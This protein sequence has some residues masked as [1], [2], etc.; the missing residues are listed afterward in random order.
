MTTPPTPYPPLRIVVDEPTKE[1]GLG[2]S[3][4]VDA[5]ASVAIGGE[6]ARFTIGIYGAWG[7]GKSSIL[8]ALDHKLSELDHPVVNFDAWRYARN[9][10]VIVPLLHE[11]EAALTTNGDALWK[12]IARGLR[13]ITS[14]ISLSAAG[15]NVS[16]SAIGN[17]IDA[18]REPRERWRAEV[19]H[20]RLQEI[21]K[22]LTDAER[23][24]VILVDDLDRC[25]PDA[26]VQLLEAIHAL[27]D[28]QGFVF[29][30]ALDYEVLIKA[31]T[32]KYA[33]AD[34]ALFIEKIIQI[35][36]WIPEVDR[37]ESVITEIVPEWEQRLGL[38]E[39]AVIT[40]QKVVHLAL[41][42]NPR[43]VKRLVNS[44]LIAQRILGEQGNSQTDG[45]ILLAVIG[46]QLQWP[47]QFKELHIALASNPDSELLGDFSADLGEQGDDVDL[48]TYLNE[49]LPGTLRAEE[50][51]AAMK[52][53]QTTASATAQPGIEIVPEEEDGPLLQ[54]IEN[55]PHREAFQW[56]RST[57]ESAGA[58]I[59]VRQQYIAFK[60]GT[61]AFLRVDAGPRIGARVFFPDSMEI[62]PEDEK[63]FRTATGA[64]AVNFAQTMIVYPT[65]T[66][67]AE[68]Y[69]LRALPT[70][71]VIS[72]RSDDRAGSE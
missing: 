55:G 36:F 66:E 22:D 35:P 69:L 18:V 70:S 25:P 45:S 44:M 33:T 52:Y 28:V 43:Q 23:R 14:E 10:N 61:R 50:V 30:L 19:P 21:G 1:L 62:D 7:V 72:E 26:I 27:T 4:Y 40:L 24:I 42:T 57:L 3:K 16:G 54:E 48:S 38:D 13:A 71:H 5:L 29:V 41:R 63:H 53:S 59:V 49:V 56:I 46:L 31:V 9:P 65:D 64:R 51:L 15:L 37:S 12:S 34:A 17:A 20:H 67:I 58:R 32:E 60:I 47:A 6:P 11:I 39:R 2:Y 8:K 68:K